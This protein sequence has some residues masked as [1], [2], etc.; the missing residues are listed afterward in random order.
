[1]TI[2]HLK[3][4]VNNNG[5]GNA[6]TGSQS[7]AV[8]LFHPFWSETMAISPTLQAGAVLDLWISQQRMK[9]ILIAAS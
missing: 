7:A 5:G 2:Q 3:Q 6:L 4:Q 8:F 9:V 1:M